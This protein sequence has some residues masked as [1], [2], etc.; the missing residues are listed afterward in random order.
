MFVENKTIKYGP[1]DPRYKDAL[2]LLSRWYAEKLVDNEYL[3]QSGTAFST[4]VLKDRVGS[5]LGS[6]FGYLTVY[7]KQLAIQGSPGVYVALPPPTG[8]TGIRSMMGSHAELDP[9]CGAAITVK[10]KYPTEISKLLDYF[11]G[12]EGQ[13]LLFFGIEGDT[14]T[15]VNGSPAYTEKITKHPT[16]AIAD[17][18]NTY[19]GY[20]SVWA[21]ICPSIWQLQIYGKE[22]RE[23]IQISAKYMGDRKIPVLQFTQEEVKE[24]QALSRDVDTYVDEWTHAFIRGQKQL[25]EWA[26]FQEGLKKLN[27]E[28]LT[29]LYQTAYA[30]YLKAAGL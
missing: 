24:V 9:A 12:T 4:K 28:R 19:V 26:T 2:T 13:R 3:G 11:Y 14:Y 15:M 6:Y 20:V 23:A 29:A 30:R 16:L 17:Y 18:V 1:T 8:P 27:T 5:M 10:S 22:G 25:A 7:N 21:S